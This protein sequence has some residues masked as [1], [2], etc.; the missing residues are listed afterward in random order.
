MA[1]PQDRTAWLRQAR[2]GL[3]VH[4]GLYSTLAR[5]EWVMSNERIGVEEYQRYADFFDPDRFD[6]R[7]IARAARQAGMGYAVL[8]AKHHEGFALFDT[9]L[10]DF[11]SM[12]ACGRDLVAEFVAACREEGLKV[13]LYYS[14]ID[15][16]HPDFTIDH[17]H[18][19][20]DHPDAA[21]LDAGRDISRYRT[22]LHGQVRELLTGYGPIDYLFY[23]FT[24]PWQKDGWAGKGPQ[25]WDSDGLLA[26][27]RD[28]QPGVVVNDRLGIPGDVV[29]PEQYQPAASPGQDGPTLVWEVCHTMN[30]SWGYDRDN[31]AFKP[32]DLLVRMLVETVA[33]GGTMLLN[34]G[35]DGRGALTAQDAASLRAL[36]EWMSLHRQS[37][38]GAGAADFR[39]THGVVMTQRADR[40]YLHLLHWPLKHLHLADLGGRVAFAR[41]LHDG[42][43]V[44]TRSSGA[45]RAG[46][47]YQ[48]A[49]ITPGEQPPGTLTIELPVVR[50]DVAVPV[51]ELFLRQSPPG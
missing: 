15:W 12:A 27:T 40:L 30:G 8:T 24:Y 20:R 16:H 34:V 19:L 13:G 47:N 3:F 25:D 41:F 18:P 7:T 2:F 36:A 37:V 49:H 43:Q 14:L 1:D 5:H 46:E 32:P 10:S 6:A 17:Q 9:H 44:R 50:P 42:S 23:D 31:Q 29:T 28:L 38:V 22:F 26:M 11:S 45:P 48:L 21:A 39:R 4:V 35:P 33:A 51:I